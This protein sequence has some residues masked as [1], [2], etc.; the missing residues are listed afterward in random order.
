MPKGDRHGKARVDYGVEGID[1]KFPLE[2]LAA[3]SPA[4]LVLAVLL[5][6][7]VP[8]ALTFVAIDIVVCTYI[9]VTA[10]TRLLNRQGRIA[11]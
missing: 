5:L 8:I 1:V 9:A 4:L 6:D 10:I 3:T 7:Y 11:V 2:L